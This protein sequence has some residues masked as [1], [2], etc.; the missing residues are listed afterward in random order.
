METW[1]KLRLNTIIHANVRFIKKFK[2]NNKE[3]NSAS[4]CDDT[5]VY[6]VVLSET[7]KYMIKSLQSSNALK[8]FQLS[9]LKKLLCISYERYT[10]T[11]I[12]LHS[13]VFPWITS[14]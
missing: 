13:T 14:T 5:V 10:G 4:I 3:S 9:E 6:G 2:K 1:L 11:S 7:I 12:E 8:L